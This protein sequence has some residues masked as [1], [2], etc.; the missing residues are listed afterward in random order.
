MK[1]EARTSNLLRAKK[2]EMPNEFIMGS[3]K[4]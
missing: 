2:Q 3:V 1:F 4:D